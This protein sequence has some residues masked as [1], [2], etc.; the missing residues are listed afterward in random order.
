MTLGYSRFVQPWLVYNVGN[1][2]CRVF[3]LKVQTVTVLGAVASERRVFDD[4]Q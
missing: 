3:F 2:D 1:D 4:P